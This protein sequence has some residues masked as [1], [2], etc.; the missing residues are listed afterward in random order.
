[1]IITSCINESKFHYDNQIVTQIENKFSIKHE[2]N[3]FVLMII[4]FSGCSPCIKPSIQFIQENDNISNLYCIITDFGIK[5]EMILNKGNNNNIIIDSKGFIYSLITDLNA[6]VL[7]FI[8]NNMIEDKIILSSSNSYDA[9]Y[10]IM[11][12]L[13]LNKTLNNE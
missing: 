9:F 8:K 1:M 6:P 11:S 10:Q 13:N 2:S 3:N 5:P 12:F 7:Y 4:P